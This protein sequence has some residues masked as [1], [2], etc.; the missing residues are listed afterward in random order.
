VD[1][2]ESILMS[3][4]IDIYA[5]FEFFTVVNV[6]IE[7]FCIVVMFSVVVRYQHFGGPWC[8]HLQGVITQRTMT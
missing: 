6:E 4:F 3:N 8:L 1:Q 7:V 5:T 2:I